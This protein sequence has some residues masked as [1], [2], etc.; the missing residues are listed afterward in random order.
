VG[1]RPL[2]FGEVDKFGIDSMKYST[3]IWEEAPPLRMVVPRLSPDRMHYEI[4]N[5]QR[6]C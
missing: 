2:Y 4:G 6:R 5:F 1:E 3:K